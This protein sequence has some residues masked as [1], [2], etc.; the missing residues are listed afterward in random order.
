MTITSEAL[1]K[2][3]A[4]SG[5]ADRHPFEEAVKSFRIEG[6]AKFSKVGALLAHYLGY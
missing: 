2:L 3:S 5:S 6:K 4:I 1:T